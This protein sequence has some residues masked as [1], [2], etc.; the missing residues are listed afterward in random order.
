MASQARIE[1]LGLER[2]LAKFGRFQPVIADAIHAVALDTKAMIAKYP[3][4][5]GNRTGRRLLRGYW[6]KVGQGITEIP[7]R[8]GIDPSSE[9]LGRKW[10]TN[11]DR[12]K[13][14]AK[15][16]NNV[17]YGPFVQDEDHQLFMHRDNGWLTVQDVADKQGPE[18]EN[19]L[20]RAV[21]AMFDG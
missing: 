7:Y 9:T 18:L 20:R 14:E 8:R 17:R 2:V 11:M 16:G 13:L 15:V 6:W 4:R 19:K 1:V 10:T 5:R 3:P 12:D 21:E